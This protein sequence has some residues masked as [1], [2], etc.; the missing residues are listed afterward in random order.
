MTSLW[1][2]KNGFHSDLEISHRTRDSHIPTSRCSSWSSKKREER[3]FT[4]RNQPV[5]RIG[6]GPESPRHGMA[7]RLSCRPGP[8]RERPARSFGSAPRVGE[9]PQPEEGGPP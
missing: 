7:K 8:P 6:S 9:L 2:P 5:H 1:K 3:K 4:Q